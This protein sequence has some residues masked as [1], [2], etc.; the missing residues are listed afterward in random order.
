[1][2]LGIGVPWIFGHQNVRRLQIAVDDDFLMRV[3]DAFTHTDEELESL[4]NRELLAIAVVDQGLAFDE[5][6]DEVGT[7]TLGGSRVMDSG[8]GGVIHECQSLTLGIETGHEFLRVHAAFDDLQGDL[9]FERLELLGLVHLPHPS[10]ADQ[11]DETVM[12]D[13]TRHLGGRE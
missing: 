12:S 8:D 13:A 4:S 10:F 6:H 3:L 7:A 2:I 9:A 1:M 11:A 5:L